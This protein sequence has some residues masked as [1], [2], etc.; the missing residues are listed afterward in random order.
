[1]GQRVQS[2]V[3]PSNEMGTLCKEEHI[4]GKGDN[5]S[6]AADTELEN[7]VDTG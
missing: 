7:P 2:Q 6:G 1:M 3:L 4:P 5:V